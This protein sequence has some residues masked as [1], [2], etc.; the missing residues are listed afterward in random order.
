MNNMLSK[1]NEFRSRS[2]YIGVDPRMELLAIVQ[3]L[4]NYDSRFHLL[5]HFNISYK[6]DIEKAFHSFRDHQVIKLFEQLSP[7]RFN[8]HAPP[9][10]MLYLSVPPQL[11]VQIPYPDDLITSAGGF[12]QLGQFLSALRDFAKVSNF[13]DFY[14]SQSAFYEAITQ[15]SGTQLVLEDDEAV[16]ETYYGMKQD[17]FHVILVPLFHEGGFGPRIERENG[18]TEI[19]SIIGPSGMNAQGQPTF[20]EHANLRS[21]VWHEFSHSFVNPLTEKYLSEVNQYEALFRPLDRGT[22]KIA[23]GS[24][25]G[26]VSELIVQAITI[27]LATREFGEAAGQAH[28]DDERQRGFIYVDM[29]VDR[30]KRYEE[31]RNRYPTFGDFYLELIKV[32]AEVKL[33]L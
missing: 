10:A 12:E 21:L 1:N 16:L 4:S 19:Y 5:T 31:Q 28:L 14:Q 15:Q 26:T 30:L 20:G 7:K 22:I 11:E 23:Y 3:Y 13:M 8:F 24:W 9:A 29:L 32:F 17:G 25:S 27:R 33:D 2:L 6:T 18:L